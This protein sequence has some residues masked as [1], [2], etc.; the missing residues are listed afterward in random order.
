[1][2]YIGWEAYVGELFGASL[3]LSYSDN[4][5]GLVRVGT[6]RTMWGFLPMKS[7]PSPAFTNSPTVP[8]A[9]FS[10]PV[11]GGP[12]ISRIDPLVS[13]PPNSLSTGIH[14]VENLRAIDDMDAADCVRGGSMDFW[15]AEKR[16]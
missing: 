14:P 5:R 8:T 3:G 10:F 6:E 12:E 13:P 7:T 1:M 11:P 16:A 2:T 15:E 9:I 4:L